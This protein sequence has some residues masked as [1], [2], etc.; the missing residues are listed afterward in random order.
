MLT[1]L[2]LTGLMLTCSSLLSQPKNRV[3]QYK[4]GHRQD[5][6]WIDKHTPDVD[7]YLAETT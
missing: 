3:Q 1:R 7:Q 4:L 5:K 6:L 2:L